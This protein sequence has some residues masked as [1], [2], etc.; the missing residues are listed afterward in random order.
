VCRVRCIVANASCI[1]KVARAGARAPSGLVRFYSNPYELRGFE[2][3][4]IPNKLKSFLI[5][6]NPLQSIWIE[7]NRTSLQRVHVAGASREPPAAGG[8]QAQ[9]PQVRPVPDA[10]VGGGEPS[11]GGSDSSAPSS[12][13][14]S[15]RP[16]AWTSITSSTGSATASASPTAPGRGIANV[17]A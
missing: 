6:I 7:N 4:L 2:R 16:P 10:Q 3:V 9:V 1:Q 8:G 17:A 15:C 13:T 14:P 11:A 5:R 12:S